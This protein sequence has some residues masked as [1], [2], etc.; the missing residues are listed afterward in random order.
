MSEI[1]IFC[2]Y[3]SKAWNKKYDVSSGF[4]IYLLQTHTFHKDDHIVFLNI[5]F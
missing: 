4:L 3:C 1:S 5:Y 2:G